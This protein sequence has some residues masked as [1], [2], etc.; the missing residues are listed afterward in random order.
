[1]DLN[2]PNKCWQSDNVLIFYRFCRIY[3]TVHMRRN[4]HFR[5][6]FENYDN[7]DGFSKS[8]FIFKQC[9]TVPQ[10][11]G[12]AIVFGLIYFT[13]WY[14]WDVVASLM[15]ILWYI[16]CWIWQWKKFENRP[17]FWWSYDESLMAYTLVLRGTTVLPRHRGTIFLRYQYRRLYGTFWYRNTTSTAVLRHGTCP[18]LTH[19]NENLLDCIVFRLKLQPSAYL[20]S[21]T[22]KLHTF[23]LLILCCFVV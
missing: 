4:G 17:I 6:T 20:L 12:H 14:V 18:L 7:A 21:F 23:Y 11:T 10:R 3:C 1:M 2:L 8:E 16:H 15:I 22:A 13:R 19:S 9:K 5:A